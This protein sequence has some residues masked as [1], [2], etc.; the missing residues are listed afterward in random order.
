MGFQVVKL[1][2]VKILLFTDVFI[3]SNYQL[4]NMSCYFIKIYYLS[5]VGQY[6]FCVYQ[7]N[8]RFRKY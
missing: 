8:F 6:V 4:R 1:C 3:T 5:L 2:K 7:F